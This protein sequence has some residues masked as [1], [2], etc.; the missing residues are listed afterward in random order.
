MGNGLIFPAKFEVFRALVQ[1]VV[2]GDDWKLEA[3]KSCPRRGPEVSAWAGSAGFLS[4]TN[5]I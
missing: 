4:S 5:R 3:E 2:H 1:L